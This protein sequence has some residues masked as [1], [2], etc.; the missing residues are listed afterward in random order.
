MR[1]SI[2]TVI[3]AT[4]VAALASGTGVAMARPWPA[5]TARTRQS[6]EP[7]TSR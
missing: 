3:G 6:R 7:S 1:K 2:A 5:A 4:A